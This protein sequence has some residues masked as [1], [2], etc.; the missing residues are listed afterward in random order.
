MAQK[1]ERTVSPTYTHTIV[2]M[3]QAEQILQDKYQLQKQ[4]GRTAAGH[5]TWLAVDRDRNESVTIKLLAFSPQMPWEELKL[6]EREAQ[7]LQTLD[8]PR[9]PKYRDYFDLDKAIGQG[10]PWFG[11]V[12]D[13]IP[14]VTLQELLEKNRRFTE[15]QIRNIAQETLEILVYLHQLN[16]S[17]LHRDIKPSNLILGEDRHIYLIDFGAVQAQAA[18]TGV[19]F[20]VVGTSGYAPLEQF[21]GRAVEASD[22]YAL[23]ATLIHLLTG[24]SPADLP[25]QDSRIQF[26]DRIKIKPDFINWLEKITELPVEKRF[27]SAAVALEALKSGRFNYHYHAS[28]AINRTIELSQPYNSLIDITKYQDKL[29]IQIPP[30]GL[31]RFDEIFNLGC[32]G[33]VFYLLF[34][35]FLALMLPLGSLLWSFI[36]IK[37]FFLMSSRTSVRIDRHG[38]AIK[39]QIFNFNYNQQSFTNEEVGDVFVQRTGSIFQVNIKSRRRIHNLGGALKQEEASWLA[40]EIRDWLELR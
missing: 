37:L 13:Y 24:V 27:K 5:Q 12:Q 16:P 6:F 15:T 35:I 34:F 25:H 19:T 36:G 7:I 28:P 29:T 21:W 10:V 38:V 14:G 40:Q 9:I 8:H 17:V 3:F 31:A 20:T 30:G 11:L 22:L 18:V 32:G 23:G 2:T 26:R 33:L 4:L 1:F 39:Y